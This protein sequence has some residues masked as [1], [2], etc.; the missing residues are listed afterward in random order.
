MK[1]KIKLLSCLLTREDLAEADEGLVENLVP[2]ATSS[3][4]MI[5]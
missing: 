4:P 5:I 2:K 1:S 3:K